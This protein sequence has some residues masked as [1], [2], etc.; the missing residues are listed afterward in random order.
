LDFLGFL[1]IL[2]SES[3]LFNGLRGLNRIFFLAGFP[4]RVSAETGA[5]GG[6]KEQDCSSGK[7]NPVSDFLQ[8][9]FLVRAFGGALHEAPAV[10]T[11]HH[12]LSPALGAKKTT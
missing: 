2:S 3:R 12:P 11:A 7:L 9:I 1:W 6:A 5:D 8:G 10:A 4:W